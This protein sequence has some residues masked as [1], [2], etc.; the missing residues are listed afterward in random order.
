[1]P[2]R[3][4]ASIAALCVVST[5]ALAQATDA[6]PVGSTGSCKDGSY[7]TH[8][9]K[10]GACSGHK[11]VKSW[12][13]AAGAAA[14]TGA[15]A[16]AAP[17][18]TTGSRPR[19]AQA[20]TAAATAPTTAAPIAKPAPTATAAPATTKT[21]TAPAAM[22]A[23]P[24]VPKPAVAAPAMAPPTRPTP[25]SAAPRVAPPATATAAAPGGGPGQ[26]WVN[27]GT[28]VYHCPGTRY[29]GKT[30]QGAYMTEEAAKA[31]GNHGDHGKSCS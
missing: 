26:G 16:A 10:S 30:R 18:P 29:Y 25:V 7:T 12:F 3:T 1:M 4:I 9:T 2:F 27:A 24:V 31:A 13:A 19:A 22:S 14:A 8:A 6:A 15:A 5:G 17:A 21:A 11:G 23:A 28:H 20:P